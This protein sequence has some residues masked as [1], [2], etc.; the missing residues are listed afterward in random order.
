MRESEENK[1]ENE[2][3]TLSP[4]TIRAAVIEIFIVTGEW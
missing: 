3:Q 2:C 4:D 1:N